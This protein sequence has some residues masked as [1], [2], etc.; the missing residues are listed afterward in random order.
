MIELC[1]Y[2]K[3]SKSVRCSWPQSPRD[4]KKVLFKRFSRLTVK[5]SILFVFLRTQFFVISLRSQFQSVLHPIFR[6][7]FLPSA[8]NAPCFRH[9]FRIQGNYCYSSTA[10][11]HNSDNLC[12]HNL[13]L[14]NTFN[15]PFLWAAPNLLVSSP[16]CTLSYKPLV[17]CLSYSLLTVDE[18]VFSGIKNLGIIN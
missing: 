12:P 11:G 13:I 9:F 18:C 8:E 1:L 3:A 14:S 4:L 16:A 7:A 2:S 5:T 15:A 10:T 17:C 6:Y